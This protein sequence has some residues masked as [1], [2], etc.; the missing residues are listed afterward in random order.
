MKRNTF[1]LIGLYIIFFFGELQAQVVSQETARQ[2]A[3]NF[4]YSRF[5]LKSLEHMDVHP[6]GNKRQPT[7]YAF[8]LFDNWVLV[9]GDKRIQPVLAYSDENSSGFPDEEDMPDGM[10]YMLEWY[11]EQIESLRNTSTTRDVN[12]Q[13]EIY[14]NTSNRPLLNR[15]VVI[16]P[17][18]T[19]DGGENI[20]NQYR[21]HGGCDTTRFY[22]K[23]CPP[24]S[25][26]CAHS[27]VGCVA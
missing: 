4:F 15:S 24:A 5:P 22:N 19:R 26:G 6:L 27:F 2:V 7:M 21:N 13:W 25:G 8:S 12:S 9:S 17:L 1:V 14:T 3:E 16:S 23:F 18:L 10:F 20:W 11:N